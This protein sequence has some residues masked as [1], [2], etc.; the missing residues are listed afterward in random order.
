VTVLDAIE[1]I[2]SLGLLERLNTEDLLRLAEYMS[3]TISAAVELGRREQTIVG[4]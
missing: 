4:G 3:K 2:D 1:E